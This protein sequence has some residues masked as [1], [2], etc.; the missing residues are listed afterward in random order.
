MGRPEGW[1]N[2]DGMA[3][4]VA[5]VEADPASVSEDSEEDAGSGASV[6]KAEV[7]D[8]DKSEMAS[9]VLGVDDGLSELA[10]METDD[11]STAV[12]PATGRGGVPVSSAPAT[13]SVA[14]ELDSLDL[15]EA[16]PD[17]PAGSVAPEA[18]VD[19]PTGPAFKA[20]MTNSAP[21]FCIPSL[22]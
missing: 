5:E 1:L 6:A 2:S 8:V 14:A 3:V 9:T 4:V 22:P 7:D 19:S 18:V 21:R 13:T 11:D 15:V 20:L 17:P 16:G 10:E 12:S